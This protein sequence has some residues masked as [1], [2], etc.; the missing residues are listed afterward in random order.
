MLENK[1]GFTVIQ[2]IIGATV[3]VLL[4]LSIF[5]AVARKSQRDGQRQGDLALVA[6]MI[7]RYAEN[8][9]GVYPSTKEAADVG[10]AFHAQFDQL[11]LQD[12]LKHKYYTLGTNFEACDGSNT[13][14]RGPG[15]VS[16]AR[17]GENGASYKLRICLENQG[18]YFFG[19]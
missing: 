17:P 11:A 3:V 14:D 4:V 5:V 16:Y 19:E 15:Y 8:H 1:R 18:E 2:F 12:P 10:S 6:G 9:H 7:E 13:N